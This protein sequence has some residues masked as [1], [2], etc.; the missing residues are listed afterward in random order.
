MAD[1]L[2]ISRAARPQ[3]LSL[4]V[5]ADDDG[6]RRALAE[7]LGGSLPDGPQQPTRVGQARLFWITPDHFWLVGG[8]YDATGLRCALAGRYIAV[9]DISDS[10][11]VFTIGGTGARELLASGTGID[12]HYRVF[13][14]GMAALTRFASLAVL[15]TQIADTPSFELFVER[16]VEEYAWKWLDTAARDLRRRPE[17]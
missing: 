7:R 15:L 14:T 5:F 1:H 2:E 4:R 16:P 3:L 13:R 17:G 9:V 12:L 6:A 11:T 10:R 8:V